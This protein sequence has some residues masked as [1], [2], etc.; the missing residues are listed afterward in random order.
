MKRQLKKEL[1]K[2]QLV[3]YYNKAWECEDKRL[4]RFGILNIQKFPK[5][6]EL[7]SKEDYKGFLLNLKFRHPLTILRQYLEK[8]KF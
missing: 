6:G 2:W 1:N 7:L 3:L 5:I 4:F 8:H